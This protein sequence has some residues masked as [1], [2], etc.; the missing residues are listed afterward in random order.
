LEWFRFVFNDLDVQAYIAARFIW[1]VA[2]LW[3]RF[4]AIDF[5]CQNSYA[6]P[7]TNPVVERL[8]QLL[9]QRPPA[10]VPAPLRGGSGGGNRA[11]ILGYWHLDDQ[12]IGRAAETRI[13]QPTL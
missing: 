5:G 1:L 13:E 12:K 6:A 2:L 11:R 7:T 10:T 3:E 8:R 9:G 4:F